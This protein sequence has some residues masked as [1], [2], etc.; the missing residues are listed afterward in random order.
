[1]CVCVWGCVCLCVREREREREAR[2]RQRQ[3]EGECVCERERERG[4]GRDSP[5]AVNLR[6]RRLHKS[7]GAL[8]K[9]GQ[10]DRGHELLLRQY[11]TAA[12]F[13]QC[14]EQFR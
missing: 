2:E 3:S 13:G 9:A 1:M 14:S 6:S 12:T 4:L 5:S 10:D 8:I 11:F 7:L